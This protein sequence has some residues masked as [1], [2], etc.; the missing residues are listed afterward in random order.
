MSAQ[1]RGTAL[2]LAGALSPDCSAC[3]RQR[4]IQTSRK[5]SGSASGRARMTRL[6]LP[7]LEQG[8]SA[9]IKNPPPLPRPSVVRTTSRSGMVRAVAI[10]GEHIAPAWLRR[11]PTISARITPGTPNSTATILLHPYEGQCFSR[12]PSSMVRETVQCGELW[13]RCARWLETRPPL[14]SP[15][16]V[17][18]RESRYQ[19]GPSSPVC[20]SGWS[21]LRQ[22]TPS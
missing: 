3:R 2:S 15:L 21:A 9:S 12:G 18:G 6:G 14:L 1:Y 17:L 13:C 8:L 19:T 5:P 22:E 16:P 20:I 10:H 4:T 7:H 11:N